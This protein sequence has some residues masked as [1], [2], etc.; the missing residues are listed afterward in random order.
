MQLG[1]IWISV[2]VSVDSLYAGISVAFWNITLCNLTEFSGQFIIFTLYLHIMCKIITFTYFLYKTLLCVHE[3][4]IL[5]SILLWDNGMDSV[6]KSQ[7]KTHPCHVF[8][9]VGLLD[10]NTC[11]NLLILFPEILFQK[12]L[13]GIQKLDILTMSRIVIVLM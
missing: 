10:F 8:S 5:Y 11:S 9:S 6:S 7:Q 12:L 4:R 3:L 2:S 13:D 1:S